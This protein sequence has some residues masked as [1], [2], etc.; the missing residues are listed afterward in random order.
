ME[1]NGMNSNYKETWVQ[2]TL[3]K[4]FQNAMKAE[5]IGKS[6]PYDYFVKE[7]AKLGVSSYMEW[8][9][10]NLDWIPGRIEGAEKK[11]GFLFDEFYV[12]PTVI[13]PETD[14]EPENEEDE[15][16]ATTT[17][18]MSWMKANPLPSLVILIF[19][20]GFFIYLIKRK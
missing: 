9:S 18:V 2:T 3:K 8:I 14:T 1:W 6:T 11:Y 15:P 16:P 12:L 10:A 7:L 13:N 20:F 5:N 19:V 17:G 4:A